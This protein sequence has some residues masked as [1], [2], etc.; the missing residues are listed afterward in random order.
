V[1][2]ATPREHEIQD[3]TI[4]EDRNV[5]WSLEG[6]D[7]QGTKI[8]L[9]PLKG[10]ARYFVELGWVEAPATLPRGRQTAA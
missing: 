2:G 4:Y 9:N 3:D 6:S 10:Y 1:R 8:T 7:L 5:R